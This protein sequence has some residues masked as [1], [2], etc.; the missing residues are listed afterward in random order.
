[1]DCPD[2]EVLQG[3]VEGFLDGDALLDFERHLEICDACAEATAAAAVLTTVP[4]GDTSDP[5]SARSEPTGGHIG[6]YAI[7]GHLGAGAMGIV[8]RAYDPKLEREVALKIL[9]GELGEAGSARLVREA[10]AMAQ[11][12]HPNVVGLYDVDIEPERVMVVMELVRGDTLASWMRRDNRWQDVLEHLVQAGRG[13]AAAHVAGLL[14]RDFK[15][16]NVLVGEDGRV[17]VTDFGIA[18]AQVHSVSPAEPNS[19]TP[20]LDEALTQI[21]AVV[22]TPAYMAPEQHRGDPLTPAADQYAF[23][24]ALF[25]GLTG[26]RPHS[27]VAVERLLEA[28][29]QGPPAWP[30]E[31]D[32]PSR[33]RLAISRALAPTPEDRFPSMDALLHALA[34]RARGARRNGALIAVA[35]VAAAAGVVSLGSSNDGDQPCAG[36]DVELSDA[37]NPRT[38]TQIHEAFSATELPYAARAWERNG[39]LL[40][41]YAA[42]WTSTY[43]DACEA[44]AIRHTQ[45]PE[46]L[47][48]RMACLHRARRMLSATTTLLAEADGDVVARAGTMVDALPPLSRCSDLS[49]LGQEL[50]PPSDAD[51]GAVELL[52]NRLAQATARRL[53]GRYS[54]ARETLD[55]VAQTSRDTGYEPARVEFLIEDAAVAEVESRYAEAGQKLR[56]AMRLG[57][58][59]GQWTEVRRASRMAIFV[60]AR[61]GQFDEAVAL[62]PLSQ[63]LAEGS[64]DLADVAET[65]ATLGA[66]ALIRGQ[67][68]DAEAELRSA[69]E[70]LITAHGPSSRR[71]AQV[72]ANLAAA[73]VELGK[74]QDAIAQF[75]QQLEVMT[76]L[77]GPGHP[78]VART[79][80]T[81]GNAHHRL[82]HLQDAERE[83][84]AALDGRRAAF[85]DHHPEVADSLASLSAVHIDQARYDEAER[86]ARAAIEISEQHE[87]PG[88]RG[89][90]VPRSHLARVLSD[91][92]RHEEA[93]EQYRRVI[94]DATKVFGA[95]S[96]AVALLRGALGH[97]LYEAGDFAA[98]ESE[99]RAALD[100]RLRA[101]GA[102]HRQ[103]VE[104]RLALA[105]CLFDQ[106]QHEDAFALFE[107]TL[108]DLDSE[109]HRDSAERATAHG[110]YGDALL[111]A[112]QSGA[113]L[114]HFEAAVRV[115][116]SLPESAPRA[117][118]AYFGLAKAR[119]ALGQENE[120]IEP[121]RQAR[122]A[123]R[124]QGRAGADR[125]DTV[126]QWLAAHD[127][128]G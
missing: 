14:H 24:M 89:S 68:A 55:T 101:L 29:M 97:A 5:T 95:Q 30:S 78:D 11:L 118:D 31:I 103:T 26:D 105:R 9:R 48:L 62:T 79:R 112:G 93:A 61:M 19:K 52:R 81:L 12:S 85:G 13:L 6:R 126:E 20:G 51:L 96:T 127:V 102:A 60:A 123:L 92:E 84:R 34:F 27:G 80:Q 43:T 111:I 82:G 47:D 104:N 63:G 16:A 70:G 106:Q 22:G 53:A 71:V 3:F 50:D 87:G 2:D 110:R 124:E 115:F 91:R 45:S 8:L 125:L 128:P 36:A 69:L 38:H 72:R 54:E 17:R 74:P 64:P 100:V 121:A 119:L 42:T 86:E 33:L 1:M 88:T 15:P 40:S 65:H 76:H 23:A 59:W 57:A 21:G 117:P 75:N 28:K 32:L 25:E 56:V 83:H 108:R 39:P 77:L 114:S 67:P 73:L 116:A 46:A 66:V 109:E 35:M 41:E 94:A 58:K 90:I 10:K 122:D 37:W 4:E 7:L 44:T 107:A 98:S 18:R 113:A 99:L 49:A 120:S